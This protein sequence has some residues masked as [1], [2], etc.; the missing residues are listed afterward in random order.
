MGVGAAWMRGN[1]VVTRLSVR[2][3]GVGKSDDDVDT[4]RLDGMAKP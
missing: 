3:Y 4:V 2:R 1:M